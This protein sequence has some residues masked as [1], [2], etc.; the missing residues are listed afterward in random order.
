MSLQN[1]QEQSIDRYLKKQIGRIPVVIDRQRKLMWQYSGSKTCHTYL[2]AQS[3]IN[4]LN[5]R[6]M[7][8]YNDWRLPTMSEAKALIEPAKTSQQL[9]IHPLFNDHPWIWTSELLSSDR[10]MVAC[11]DVGICLPIF[12][13]NGI[14]YV[15]AVREAGQLN[16]IT[17]TLNDGS[18]NYV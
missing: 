15:R 13:H 11:F 14:C 5:F 4:E 10:A 2:G 7:C 12:I 8:G 1:G 18:T 6:S 16:I 17:N 3:Y 9:F